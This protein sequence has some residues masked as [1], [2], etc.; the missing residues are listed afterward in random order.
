MQIPLIAGKSEHVMMKIISSQDL[1]YKQ[2]HRDVLD[3]VQR[4]SRKRVGLIAEMGEI[5]NIKNI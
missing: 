3:K 2:A 5:L 4:L 1:V